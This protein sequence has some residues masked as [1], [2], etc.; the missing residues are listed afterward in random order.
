MGVAASGAGTGDGVK[1]ASP[2][3]VI[4]PLPVCRARQNQPTGIASKA[5]RYGQDRHA[6]AQRRRQTC[7]NKP[8]TMTSSEELIS[9]LQGLAPYSGPDTLLAFTKAPEGCID[10]THAHP[11]GLAQL[12]TGRR[13][14]LS[15]LIRDSGQYTVAVR[16]ARTLRAKIFELGSDRGID[17][18]Y[19]A[20]G[21]A[22]WTNAPGRCPAPCVRPG[23]A[24]RRR[25]HRPPRPGRL[26]TS[27]HRAGPHQPGPGPQPQPRPRDRL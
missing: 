20:A 18:G 3:G 15:T 11:S 9:W 8:A 12:L 10:L 22:S 27:A 17:V 7:P 1:N 16:A 13:T 4:C 23:A 26:R 21:T 19:L 6:Q 14:R 25:A 24:D 2:G 5:C